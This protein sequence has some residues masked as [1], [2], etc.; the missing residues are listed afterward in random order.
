MKGEYF[1]RTFTHE[2]PRENVTLFDKLCSRLEKKMPD[3]CTDKLDKADWLS[4]NNK[5]VRRK[6]NDLYDDYLEWN[7]T[8][9]S[10]TIRF[11]AA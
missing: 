3:D 10:Y 9:C 7:Q 4:E 2:I 5:I 1:Q 8:R 6:C 11:F